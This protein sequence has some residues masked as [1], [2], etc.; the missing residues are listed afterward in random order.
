MN[1]KYKFLLL[2]FFVWFSY[3]VMTNLPKDSNENI[4]ETAKAPEALSKSVHFS[5]V[6]S[7]YGIQSEHTAKLEGEDP[8]PRLKNISLSISRPSVSVVDINNDGLMDIFI[9]STMPPKR[10]LLYINKD[11]KSFKESAESYGLAEADSEKPTAMAIFAD[12]NGDG[13]TD[14]LSAKWG[15]V[16]RLFFGT[17]ARKFVEAKSPFGGYSSFPGGVN[18]ADFNLD[19]KLD[20]VFGNYLPDDGTGNK[21]LWGLAPRQDNRTGGISRIFI[22]KATGQFQEPAELAIPRRPYTTTVGI[23]D[24]N[25][26]NYPDIFLPSDYSYDR[27]LINQNGKAVKG[28]VDTYLPRRFHGFSGMN[29]EFYDFND[30][31]KIDL[32]VSNIFKPRFHNAFNLLWKKSMTDN[33]FENVSNDLGVARCGFSW[34]AK[35]ADFNNDGSADLIVVNGRSRGGSKKPGEGTSLWYKRSQVFRMPRF[36]RK[37]YITNHEKTS[38]S[39]VSAFERPCLFVQSEGHFYDLALEAGLD[40]FQEKRGLAIF[41]IN[42]DGKMDFV[43]TAYYG[44]LRVYQNSSEAKGNWI[45]FKLVNKSGSDQIVGAKV[46]VVRESGKLRAFETYPAN[47][48]AGQSDPRIHM[49]LGSEQAIKEIKIAWP[50]GKNEVFKK[51]PINRYSV[52]KEGHGEIL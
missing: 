51:L 32:Y 29:S 13:M 36:L 23:S 48:Y 11:G 37:E 30:D 2:G 33:T 39:Y 46:I 43:Y 17:K 44:K 47:G 52:L 49:G 19:G 18:V 21:A 41:D 50:N 1:A 5:E 38:D 25:E 42:N 20:V 35:F 34:G 12:F 10:N 26:D 28:E 8:T 14:F 7:L 24:I 45:G 6:S 15:G 31:G 4:Y 22:Q 16:H 9:P 27:L 40:D 3:Y